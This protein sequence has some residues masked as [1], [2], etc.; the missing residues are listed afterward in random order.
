MDFWSGKAAANEKG[1][2]V[3]F[4]PASYYGHREAEI[5]MMRLFGGFGP[6]CEAAYAEVWPLQD[7][8]EQ[9]ITLYRLYHELNHLNLFGRSY[10][11]TCLSTINS[12]L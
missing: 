4:D 6:R 3:I 8:Y 11:Q 2:P 10:Y 7:G 5:G 12:L 9:R 1:E